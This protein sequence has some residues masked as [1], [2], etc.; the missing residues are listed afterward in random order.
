[1]QP[2]MAAQTLCAWHAGATFASCV[3]PSLVAG[4]RNIRIIT[5][6]LRVSSGFCGG[7]FHVEGVG[8]DGATRAAKDTYARFMAANFRPWS[9]HASEEP[10][11][12]YDGWVQWLQHLRD[13]ACHDL[14]LH[15]VDDAEAEGAAEGA[16]AEGAEDR[17]WRLLAHGR[18][19]VLEKIGS[20]FTVPADVKKMHGVYRE[21]HSDLWGKGGGCAGPTDGDD[22][23]TAKRAAAEV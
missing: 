20:E 14:E 13:D 10:D 9:C 6:V 21:M 2:R 15:G 17:G 16:A 8:Q 3:P 18:L 1:M 11:L 5:D 7:A 4:M 19:L 23:A 22:G 12:S